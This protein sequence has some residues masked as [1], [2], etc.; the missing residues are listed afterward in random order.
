MARFSHL[1]PQNVEG[2]KEPAAAGFLLGR[3]PPGLHFHR[4]S[5]L[6]PGTGSGNIS[7]FG[8]IRLGQ[9]RMQ[10]LGLPVRVIRGAELG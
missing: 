9:G 3:N 4:K 8:H 6:E 7:Q 10:D 2:R 1:F 5:A